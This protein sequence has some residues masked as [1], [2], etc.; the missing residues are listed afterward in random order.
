MQTI[1]AAANDSVFG[2]VPAMSLDAVKIGRRIGEALDRKGWDYRELASRITQDTSS[3]RKK[4]ASPETVRLWITGKII[5]PYDKLAQLSAVLG[6]PEEWFLFE[7]KPG[8]S[9]KEERLFLAHVSQSEMLILTAL[10]STNQTGQEMIQDQAIAM[11]RRFPAPT[12]EVVPFRRKR[13][14]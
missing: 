14:G 3:G 10:R 8:N 4:M 5:P 11:Q 13:K 6:E 1:F 12:A 2:K 9:K 7:I